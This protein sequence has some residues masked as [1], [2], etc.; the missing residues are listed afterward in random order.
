M[1]AAANPSLAYDLKQSASGIVSPRGGSG[2][3]EPASGFQILPKEAIVSLHKLYDSVDIDGSGDLNQSEVT[4]LLKKLGMF[5]DEDE[6]HRVYEEMD[7][8]RSGDV[9]FGEFATQIDKTLYE[10]Y[11]DQTKN[12]EELIKIMN[13]FE[14]IK[15]GFAG[16]TWRKQANV[17]WMMNGGV[18]IITASVMLVFTVQGAFLLIPMTMAYFFTYV[19]GPIFDLFYQRPLLCSGRPMCYEEPPQPPQGF[20]G[21]PKDWPKEYAR[22]R[23]HCLNVKKDG[24]AFDD[25]DTPMGCTPC[26]EL[27][28]TLADIFFLVRPEPPSL[29]PQQAACPSLNPLTLRWRRGGV[30]LRFPETAALLLTLAL[31][32]GALFG[33]LYAVYL[34]IFGML[35]E[36][37]NGSSCGSLCEG[38]P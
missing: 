38:D 37:S 11:A 1:R 2:L 30:Q 7:R 8:D 14:E 34:Q 22:Q 13:D 28:R 35:Y 33:L 18:M 3:P 6:A 10:A 17:I 27:Q 16:T 36:C 5:T 9:D 20:Q 21:D 24:I 23:G 15:T 31:A 25:G 19:L 29:S 26:A 32:F 12:E 4:K